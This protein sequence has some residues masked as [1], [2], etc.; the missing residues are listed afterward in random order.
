M[1]RFVPM[2]LAVSWM[3][4]AV[5]LACAADKA[6]EAPR[7]GSAGSQIKDPLFAQIERDLQKR[8]AKPEDPTKQQC[9]IPEDEARVQTELSLRRA[10]GKIDYEAGVLPFGAGMTRP[11]RIAGPI[12]QYTEQALKEG[13]E[14]L[15]IIKCV[16]TTEGA[17]RQ[18]RTLKALP[19]MEGEVLRS[20]YCTRWKP[21]TFQDMPRTVDYTF[22][23]KLSLPGKWK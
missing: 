17:V 3:S 16:V 5:L 6:Q 7:A 20:L 19:H 1:T 15:M 10:N 13:V 9:Q 4:T 18:C 12:P 21:I 14:G 23:I 8:R 2:L 11:E 22:N